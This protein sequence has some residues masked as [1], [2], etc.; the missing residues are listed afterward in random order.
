MISI[1][2]LLWIIVFILIYK[3]FSWSGYIISAVLGLLRLRLLGITTICIFTCY[4]LP[5]YSLT[6][7]IA[8]AL[9]IVLVV[10]LLVEQFRNNQLTAPKDKQKGKQEFYKTSLVAWS[11]IFGFSFASILYANLKYLLLVKVIGLSMEEYKDSFLVGLSSI[12]NAISL[13]VIYYV[14]IALPLLLFYRAWDLS[15]D[16]KYWHEAEKVTPV[17]ED[18]KADEAVLQQHEEI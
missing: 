5:K 1:S 3:I 7:L 17:S 16:I 9:I 4:Y 11:K 10:K 15:E 2:V 8:I 6:N 13:N 14:I 18:M 12:F